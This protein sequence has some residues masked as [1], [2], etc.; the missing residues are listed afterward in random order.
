MFVW[1]LVTITS[2]GEPVI[3]RKMRRASYH[4]IRFRR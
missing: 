2:T 1:D 4:L 3:A